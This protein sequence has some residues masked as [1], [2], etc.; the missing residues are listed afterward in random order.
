MNPERQVPM[1]TGIEEMGNHDKFT[2]NCRWLE[3]GNQGLSSLSG[4]FRRGGPVEWLK[5]NKIGNKYRKG[6]RWKTWEG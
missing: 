1:M 6:E 4:R 5:E 3:D 2:D